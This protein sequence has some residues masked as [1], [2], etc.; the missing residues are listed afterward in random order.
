MP[1]SL[2]AGNLPPPVYVGPLPQRPD[3]IVDQHN[4]F[5]VDN[6][7]NFIGVDTNWGRGGPLARLLYAGRSGTLDL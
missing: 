6:D 2:L 1:D 4:V 7:G 5:L 3:L